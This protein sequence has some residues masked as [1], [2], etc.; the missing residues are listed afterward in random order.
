M[1]LQ[2]VLV[3]T[4]R[5][6]AI[7]IGPKALADVH[8]ETPLRSRCAVLTDATVTSLYGSRLAKLEQLEQLALL[9]GE[10]SKSFAALE[11]SLE[12]MTSAGFD[13]RSCLIALG[14]GVVGDLG[15]LAASL[16]MRGIAVVHC[17]T[18]LLAQVDSSVGGKTAINL[19]RGKNLAGTFHQPTAVYADTE[20]LATLS[21]P[22]YH[23]G[24]GEVV[25]SALIA[26][27][28]TFAFLEQNLAPIR[29]RDPELLAELVTR[30]VQLKADLVA[31]DERELG[32]RKLLNLGH[33]FGHAIEHAAGY[34]RVPHG[35]AVAVGLSLALASARELD[36]LQDQELPIRLTQL[37]HNLS[38]P[39]T[40]VELS[41]QCG[42][43]LA[44]HDLL[45]GMRHDK[46]GAM[47]QP[48]LV[49]PRALGVVEH[50]I[51]PD[52]AFWNRFWARRAS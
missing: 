2:S 48:R 38:L 9:P 34:G 3:R 31:R 45:S 41:A 1:N 17:P 30:T 18:T 23:S 44:A 46:K 26:G 19:S 21:D 29:E 10:E 43:R 50:D 51:T 40:L 5:P 47:G 33:T 28:E 20:T 24:L 42:I 11:R 32:P 4:S 22:E 8:R 7:H 25:K 49:I 52:P 39:A 6:Y 35:I 15:G 27:E 36:M 14:G 13:R 12:F 16:Y 37:L